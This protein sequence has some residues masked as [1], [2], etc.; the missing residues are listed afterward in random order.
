MAGPAFLLLITRTV[1]AVTRKRLVHPSVYEMLARISGWLLIIYVSLESV[2]TLIWLN[3]TVPAV[4][5]LGY[6]FY[7]QPTLPFDTFL[8]YVPSWQENGGFLGVIAYG[9]ILFSLSYRYLP[10]YPR[11]RE[12]GDL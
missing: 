11:E 12:L 3:R 5:Y 6:D 9:V 2:D 7:T 8:S 1:S 10:L 4:G